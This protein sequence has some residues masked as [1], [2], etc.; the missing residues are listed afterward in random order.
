MRYLL[1]LL[2]LLGG[3]G[4]CVSVPSH[5]ELRDTTL[6]L[7]FANG[8]CSGTAIAPDTILSA[9]H[10]FAGQLKTINGTPVTVVESHTESRDRIVVKV[11]GIRFKTWA[12]RGPTPIQ[13]DKL[14]FWGNPEGGQDLYREAI[15]S[16]AWTD[17]LVLQTIVCGGDSGSGLFDAQGRVVG[18]VSAVTGDRVCKFGLSL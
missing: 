14:R 10:C 11:A 9:K 3:C 18:I 12:K 4:G 16:R 17:G 6:R 2:L 7:E 15:V 5:G 1:P 13:G 8:L